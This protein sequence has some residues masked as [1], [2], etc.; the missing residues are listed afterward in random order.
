MSPPSHQARIYP[1]LVRSIHISGI[2]RNAAGLFVMYTLV[3]LFAFRL[4]WFTPTLAI[5]TALV[6]LPTLRRATKRDPQILAVY[7][8]HVLRAAIYQGHP[9]YTHPHRR[10][11]RTL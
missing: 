2:E 1:A 7:R 10:H 4:N 8:S 5:L 6:A 11:A 9:P 3:M